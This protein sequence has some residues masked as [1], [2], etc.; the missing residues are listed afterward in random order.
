MPSD[1]PVPRAGT[2]YPIFLGESILNDESVVEYVSVRYKF[3]PSTVS[4]ARTGSLSLQRDPSS[5]K[6]P[7]KVTWLSHLNMLCG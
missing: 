1:V 6:L 2:E 4:R 3:R 7:I 5:D